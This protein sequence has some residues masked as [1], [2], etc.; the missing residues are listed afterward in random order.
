M[1]LERQVAQQEEQIEPFAPSESVRAKTHRLSL[2]ET[3]QKG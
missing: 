2:R 1:G 3:S